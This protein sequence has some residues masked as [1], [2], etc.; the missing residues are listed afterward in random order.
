MSQQNMNTMM[1]GGQGEHKITPRLCN[2]LQN[3]LFGKFTQ[4]IIEH[5]KNEDTLEKYFKIVMKEEDEWI[6]NYYKNLDLKEVV[7]KEEQKERKEN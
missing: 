1:G 6:A 2:P 7:K 3:E 5:K 4:N